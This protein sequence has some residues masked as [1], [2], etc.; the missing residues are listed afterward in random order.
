MCLRLA[1]EPP[2]A[3]R[4]DSEHV[5]RPEVDGRLRGQL[6][7]VEEISA[8][9]A[10]TA[11]LRARGRT[12]PALADDRGSASLQRLELADD[13]I[14]AA[15]TAAAPRAEAKPVRPDA[16]RVGELERLRRRRQRVRH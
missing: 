16:Q 13:P 5:S 6:S 11:A 4:L 12:G 2:A 14:T 10:G 1:S 8:G 15:L 7:P 3:R 9:R